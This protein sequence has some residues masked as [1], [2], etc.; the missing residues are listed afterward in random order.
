MRK[1]ILITVLL[2][3]PLFAVNGF[4][5]SVTPTSDGE[6]L[7][8]SIVGS[9]IS[10]IDGSISYIGA[11]G[12][13]PSSGTFSDGIASGLGIDSGIIL[14]SGWASDA[15]GPNLNGGVVEV[16]SGGGSSDDTTQDLNIPGDTDLSSIS[17]FATEDATV[18][19]FDFTTSGG[20]LFFNFVFGSEEYIDFVNT[21]Y[22]D[23]FAFIVDDVNI[24]LVPDTT[25]PVTIN[26][27]NPLT[28]PAYYVNNINPAPHDIEYDGFTTVIQAQALGLGTGTHSI[29]L[30]IA[31]ASDGLLD[32]G[33]FIE[34]GSFSDIP[35]EPV[36]DLDPE[37]TPEPVP[38]PA[39]LFLLGAGLIG[40]AGTSRKTFRK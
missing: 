37:P 16:L 17:G 32:S 23:V 20:D 24:G 14:T 35:T 36:P 38:E 33:V 39:T 28:N 15:D 40:F 8:S 12:P 29:K 22:N 10:V 30:A 34:A 1:V 3:L 21:E 6:T 26:T 27:V 4:T 2:F 13:N 5:L 31:D 18:L 7:V 19:E 9:G 25:D 11:T